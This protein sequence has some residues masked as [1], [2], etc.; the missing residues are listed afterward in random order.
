MILV[1]ANLLVCSH[2]ASLAQHE[3][4]RTYLDARIDS[5]SPVGLPWPRLT[6]PDMGK[7]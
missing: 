3:K 6:V 7:Q 4:A 1:D 2:L 5:A